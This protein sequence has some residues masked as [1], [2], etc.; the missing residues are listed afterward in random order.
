M[1]NY[2]KMLQN[3]FDKAFSI[4]MG[5]AAVIALIAAILLFIPDISKSYSILNFSVSIILFINFVL[6]KKIKASFKIKLFIFITIIVAIASFIGGSVT[7]AFL[8]I[9]IISNIV[10][11]L[12]L[13]PRNSVVVSII[14]VLIIIGL[15]YYYPDY[16]LSKMA[17]SVMTWTLQII[18]LM[19]LLAV[20]NISAYFMKKLLIENIQELEKSVA[21]SNQLAYF[22]QL[23]QLPNMNKFMVDVEDMIQQNQADGFIVFLDIENMSMINAT[24]GHEFGDK[25]LIE[26]ANVLELEIT[27]SIYIARTGGNEFALWFERIT[28]EAL[29]DKLA[30][31]ISKLKDG[32]SLNNKLRI[33]IAYSIFSNG[34]ETLNISY[35]KATFA[36]TYAKN[37]KIQEITPYNDMIENELRRKEIIKGLI[38]EAIKNEEI[39]LYYQ[40]K[41]DTE[42]NQVV[43]VEGLARWET[44]ELGFISP[45]EFLPII[46]SLNLSIELGNYVV[47]QACR[48]FAMLQEKYNKDISVAI[49]I[50]PS[51]IINSDIIEMMK[52]ILNKYSIPK[53]KIYIEITEDI[54]INEIEVVKP[55]IEALKSLGL[56]ISLDDFGSGF[57]S[58][59]TLTQLDI[60]EI[61][62]DKSIVDQVGENDRIILLLENIMHL[63]NQFDFEIIVEG[64][65]TELQ[66]DVLSKLG[67]NFIQ[68]FYYGRPEPLLKNR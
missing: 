36:L 64:V 62:V 22:D 19:L 24:L 13:R 48:D 23:T 17:N 32:T 68:G 34:I 50:S 37:N 54:I 40:P 39:V 52:V 31:I 33:N 42:K 49:N 16:D 55:I 14:T 18:G 61:K 29:V 4:I 20:L 9:L 60:D 1:K 63:A 11:A 65:E 58:L 66:N 44:A 35:Q 59:S 53:N 2:N 12:F 15:A 7:S 8:S 46:E 21:Y 43:G 30:Q 41:Y 5:I 56:K 10:A 57:S 67:F 38:S 3:K 6:R 27:E 25:L 28:E 45:S 51:H 47:K 26:V